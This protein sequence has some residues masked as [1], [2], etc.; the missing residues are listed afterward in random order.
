MNF[1][2]HEIEST[3]VGDLLAQGYY[4][5]RKVQT[6]IRISL[7]MDVEGTNEKQYADVVKGSIGYVQGMVK[8]LPVVQFDVVVNGKRLRASAGIKTANLSFDVPETSSSSGGA[9]PRATADKGGALPK[10]MGFLK[11]DAIETIV[12]HPWG[13]RSASVAAET[14]V[15]NL[16]SRLGMSLACL[17][18]S[19]PDYTESDFH[20]VTRNGKT[21]V[22][23]AKDFPAHGI[24][25]VPECTEWK[26]RHW[27]LGGRS[28]LVKY[29]TMYPHVLRIL[30]FFH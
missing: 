8:G 26:D 25:L 18:D 28:V 5:G 21:E 14:K 29:G 30:F 6:K 24:V 27:S 23:T 11:T 12:V 15:K 3:F 17:M 4:I 10:G 16:H 9:A 20:L 7:N 19:V 22:W 13:G 1:K 2:G